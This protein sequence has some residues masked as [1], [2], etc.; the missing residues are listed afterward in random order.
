MREGKNRD[1]SFQNFKFP[2]ENLDAFDNADKSAIAEGSYIESSD[3]VTEQINLIRQN[4]P[5]LSEEALAQIEKTFRTESKSF[6]QKEK[7]LLDKLNSTSKKVWDLKYPLATGA[8]IVWCAVNAVEG[9]RQ[10]NAMDAHISEMQISQSSEKTPRHRPPEIA[11]HTETERNLDLNLRELIGDD[12]IDYIES[13]KTESLDKKEGK[14]AINIEGFEKFVTIP[15]NKQMREL[16][17]AFPEYYKL[18]LKNLR[19]EAEGK[20]PGSVQDGL[21]DQKFVEL[22]YT[23]HLTGTVVFEKGNEKMMGV[24]N[25]MMIKETLAHEAA[26]NNSWHNKY[27]SVEQRLKLLQNMIDRLKSSNRFQSNYVESIQ[28]D[29]EQKELLLKAG[30]YWAEINRAYIGWDSSRLPDEDKKII[31]SMLQEL[32]LE[33]DRAKTEDKFT[34]TLG[35]IYEMNHNKYAEIE[36][37]NEV[38]KTKLKNNS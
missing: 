16:V 11:L 14:E 9:V 3:P 18:N 22:G 37:Q 12:Q 13:I 29:D 28:N 32:H 6:E 4:R 1:E 23:N 2:S 26:H 15:S 38:Q 19:Y 8:L 25:P 24:I 7:S 10:N 17:D 34:R 5:H 21:D 30:E 31:E 36:R 33:F 27:L 20:I 35:K